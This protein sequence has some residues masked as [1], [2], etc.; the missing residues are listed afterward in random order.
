[1]KKETDVKKEEMEAKTASETQHYWLGFVMGI[2][3]C[4]TLWLAWVAFAVWLG[5]T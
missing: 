1:M 5:S 3:C 4:F 2:A